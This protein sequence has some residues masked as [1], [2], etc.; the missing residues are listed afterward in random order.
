MKQNPDGNTIH[1][2]YMDHVFPDLMVGM[3]QLAS[4]FEEVM[5]TSFASLQVGL[6]ILLSCPASRNTVNPYAC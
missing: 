3:D 2:Q 6:I 5:L 4:H 1:T